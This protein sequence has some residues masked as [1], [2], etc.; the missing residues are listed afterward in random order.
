MIALCKSYLAFVFQV[1]RSFA[2]FPTVATFFILYAKYIITS[3]SIQHTYPYDGSINGTVLP[4]HHVGRYLRH[5]VPPSNPSHHRWPFPHFARSWG[6]CKSPWS[7][8][9]SQA[10]G[11]RWQTCGR[12]S[13]VLECD[14]TTRTWPPR[15]RLFDRVGWPPWARELPHPLPHPHPRPPPPPHRE[16]RRQMASEKTQ[17]K[18]LAPTT[19][20]RNW[21]APLPGQDR[22]ER[23]LWV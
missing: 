3:L 22:G 7:S 9:S 18:T 19:M 10:A 5:A 16:P 23:R 11:R 17:I 1:S 12:I 2:A 8:S 4:R 20:T 15:L 13:S 21:R 6:S 14:I